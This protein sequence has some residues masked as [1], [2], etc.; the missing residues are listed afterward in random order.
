MKPKAFHQWY[1]WVN[2]EEWSTLNNPQDI[3]SSQQL[4]P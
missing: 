3:H 2:E 1:V 4:S